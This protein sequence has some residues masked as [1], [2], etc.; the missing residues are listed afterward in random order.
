MKMKTFLAILLLTASTTLV[1][2]GGDGPSRE[3]LWG[4]FYNPLAS[5]QIEETLSGA[6]IR[7][8]LGQ[9]EHGQHSESGSSSQW[10]RDE[11]FYTALAR[12]LE[13]SDRDLSLST[14]S[15]NEQ[16]CLHVLV[17]YRAPNSLF[18][19]GLEAGHAD[20]VSEGAW[21]TDGTSAGYRVPHEDFLQWTAL[22]TPNAVTLEHFNWRRDANRAWQT[23]V[24]GYYWTCDQVDPTSEAYPD[25]YQ[26]TAHLPTQ[27][28]YKAA[29]PLIE[30]TP[31]HEFLEH[32]RL[33]VNAPGPD[34]AR[35]L[36]SDETRALVQRHTHENQ[37][38]LHEQI[39]SHAEYFLNL[40]PEKTVDYPGGLPLEKP[41]WS[42][43][44]SD[45]A[46]RGSLELA[47][48]WVNDDSL[49]DFAVRNALYYRLNIAAECRN[50]SVRTL[51][52]VEL[53]SIPVVWRA[54]LAALEYFYRGDF[55]DAGEA[56]AALVDSEQAYVAELSSY[57]AGRSFQL[58]AQR[59]WSGYGKPDDSIDHELLAKAEQY[60]H[61]HMEQQGRYADSA[62]GLLRRNAFLAADL[63]LYQSRFLRK[64]ER[65]FLERDSAELLRLVQEGSRHGQ[66]AALVESLDVHYETFAANENLINFIP[67]LDFH[68]GVQRFHA[69]D[70]VI[71]YEQLLATNAPMAYP[72]LVRIAEQLDDRERQRDIYKRFLE[73]NTLH[74]YLALL[75]YP[76][77]GPSV[78]LSTESSDLAR[79]SALAHCSVETLHSF[80]LE[81]SQHEYLPVLRNTLYDAYIQREEFGKLHELMISG[82]FDNGRYEAIRTAVRQLAHQES[83]GKAYMNIG[84]F[85][86][87]QMT[88]PSH[89]GAFKLLATADEDRYCKYGLKNNVR[90]AQHFYHQSLVQFGPNDRS[91]DEAKALHYM[92]NC[93]RRGRHRCWGVRPKDAESSEVLFRRLH[94]KY[95][96]GR[97]TERTPYYY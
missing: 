76:Q 97:W 81:H 36:V 50:K 68:R 75:D 7:R 13:R 14:A 88:A 95:P 38:S 61:R 30:G 23:V 57:L 89:S 73:G 46:L 3:E 83:L 26:Q 39:A 60:F 65:A 10:P 56:F 18:R 20:V 58:A 21:T 34:T 44:I 96:D 28:E 4:N 84:Y 80:V 87:T 29:L 79:E 91:E 85:V 67:L 12:L 92:I 5:S 90:G 2:G 35:Y 33:F 52:E 16:G 82:K 37:M 15:T 11:S 71:A 17:Q 49:S 48:E 25:V 74:L 54:Y 1:A 53:E 43:C 66:G 45:G 42:R 47:R 78:F 86:A 72:Y 32:Y 64:L 55:Q 22:Q 59:D 41:G 70:W 93:D 27:E 9:L 62:E 6:T 77:Y 40:D 19:I 63:D 8:I 31:A 69:G 94:T 51:S 24:R